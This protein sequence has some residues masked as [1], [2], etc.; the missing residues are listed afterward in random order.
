[1]TIF[2]AETFI[3]KPGKMGEYHALAEK[4]IAF[5]KDHPE[6][7][8]ELLSRRGFTHTWGGVVGGCVELS[9]FNSMAEAESCGARIM[10]HQEFMASIVLPSM[11]M[12]VPGS[13]SIQIWNSFP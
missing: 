7:F 8:K 6:L 1:M 10:Q 13:Y 5:V 3:I 12:Y 9:E 11:D 2:V 4:Y